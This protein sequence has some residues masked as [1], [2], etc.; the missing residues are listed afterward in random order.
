M[1]GLFSYFGGISS[2]FGWSFS[3][4]VEFLAPVVQV[5]TGYAAHYGVAQVRFLGQLLLRNVQD[6]P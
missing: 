6:Y 1:S 4:P 3:L 5:L 2:T